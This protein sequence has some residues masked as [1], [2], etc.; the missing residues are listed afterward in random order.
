LNP[1]WK[2]KE[3]RLA[4]TLTYGSAPSIDIEQVKS[5]LKDVRRSSAASI[6]GLVEDFKN[7]SR[8]VFDG[9][10]YAR[11]SGEAAVLIS[12]LSAD[13]PHLCVNRS[14]AVKELFAGLRAKG[15]LIRETYYDEYDASKCQPLQNALTLPPE[16]LWQSFAIESYPV[17]PPG[18][19]RDF[20][21]IL[22][23]SAISVDGSAFFVQ[24]LRNIGGILREA[25]RIV[26]IVGLDKL[27]G[28]KED[29]EFQ[30]RCMAVFGLES[31]VTEIAESYAEDR[32]SKEGAPE[33]LATI[34]NREVHAV[35]VDDG[36][37]SILHSKLKP[38]HY[39]IGCRACARACPSYPY[40]RG[41]LLR[42]PK[43]YLADFL[44]GREKSTG[45]CLQCGRCSRVCPVMDL[46]V[47]VSEAR[48]EDVEE[49]SL[50]VSQRLFNQMILAMNMGR[51]LPS[52][53]NAAMRNTAVR[54]VA[55][56]VVGLEHSRSLPS[57]SAESALRTRTGRTSKKHGT[58]AYYVGCFEENFDE[59]SVE[60][61]IKVLERSG[62]DVLIPK[63]KC[64][65]LPHIATGDAKA[66]RKLARF[67]LERLKE[68]LGRECEAIISSC[69]SCA[70]TLKR[71][72]PRVLGEEADILKGKVHDVFQFL[73]EA[74]KRGRCDLPFKTPPKRVTYHVPCHVHLQETGAPAAKLMSLI[75]GVDVVRLER[76]CCGM[77]GSYGLKHTTFE[78][79]LAI[80]NK[81]FEEIKNTSFDI[82][83]TDCAGCRMQI[84]SGTGIEAVHPIR[85]LLDWLE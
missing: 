1:S 6:D 3:R 60:A 64:C 65:G 19:F 27:V 77:A 29:A 34:G 13:T 23:V 59:K 56:S 21:G 38:L 28:T 26:L 40:L 31:V 52:L 33:F 80:G 25:K 16:V 74:L 50:P 72:Y 85:L 42:S 7:C 20:T 37:R 79:S 41:D 61:V 73:L 76:H 71:E 4:R 68:A 82:M 8:T 51:K 49:H 57:F 35:I 18:P 2:D 22:G 43:E 46:D 5:K 36:R 62:F 17:Q 83:T 24:H 9:V 58:L 55:E 81:L 69:P 75:P 30:A 12:R 54:K 84:E 11:D 70:S 15:F 32:K 78:R 44:K 67:N 45:H 53:A 47:M 14:G 10:A 63:H 39:C 66:G 48:A